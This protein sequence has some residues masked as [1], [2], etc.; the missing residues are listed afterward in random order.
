MDGQNKSQAH[1]HTLLP[2]FFSHVVRVSI[3]LSSCIRNPA[4]AGVSFSDPVVTVV[5]TARG[6]PASDH[7]YPILEFFGGTRATVEVRWL[8][9][10]LPSSEGGGLIKTMVGI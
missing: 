8:F 1:Q 2:R 9:F 7:R 6:V 3:L 4:L 5:A 10:Y